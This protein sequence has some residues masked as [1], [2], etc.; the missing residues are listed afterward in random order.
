MLLASSWITGFLSSLCFLLAPMMTVGYT[1]V[2]LESVRG[3]D[4]EFGDLFEGFVSWII[5]SYVV[6]VVYALVFAAVAWVVA[7]PFGGAAAAG[8][9]ASASLS[10]G[11]EWGL[12]IAMIA[13][14]PFYW[15]GFPAVADGAEPHE[16]LRFAVLGGLHN[17][18]SLVLLSVLVTA[19]IYVIGL[20]AALVAGAGHIV[21]ALGALVL[22]SPGVFVS[23]CSA[24]E[25][26][27]AREAAE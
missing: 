4:V 13:L 14:T 27:Y 11:A 23:M 1:T 20:L 18:P 8:T 21:I 10:V 7:L 22:I 6:A 24:Y 25:Q 16:A 5:P 19:T 3:E 26:V 2:C 15:L 9:G 17:W 12:R